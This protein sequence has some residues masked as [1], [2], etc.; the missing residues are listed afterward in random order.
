LPRALASPLATV[1][2]RFVPFFF[3]SPGGPIVEP[4]AGVPGLESD[5]FSPFVCVLGMVMGVAGE[6]PD[7]TASFGSGASLG[8]VASFAGEAAGDSGCRRLRNF[9]EARLRVTTRRPSAFREGA[10]TVWY[11]M[12]VG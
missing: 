3:K 8:L 10:M 4:L 11:K 1:D 5:A 12:C 2:V 7:S 9:D 6:S